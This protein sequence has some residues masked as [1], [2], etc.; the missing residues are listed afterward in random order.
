MRRTF[1]QRLAAAGDP[2]KYD[3]DQPKYRVDFV[4]LVANKFVKLRWARRQVRLAPL[5]RQ[6][7]VGKLKADAD[8]G[9]SYMVVY[10]MVMTE[11]EIKTEIENGSFTVNH[12]I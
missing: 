9:K 5:H 10:S 12:R 7:M 11:L 2:R 3:L 6:I 4:S 1:E 8:P